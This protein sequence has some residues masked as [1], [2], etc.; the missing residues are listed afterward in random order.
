MNRLAILL[1]TFL[2]SFQREK[3]YIYGNADGTDENLSTVK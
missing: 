1:S 2:R 3:R